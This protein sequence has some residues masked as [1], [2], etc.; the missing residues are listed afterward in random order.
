VP[1]VDLP[2]MELRKSS[3]KIHCGL[4]LVKYNDNG[5]NAY[6]LVDSFNPD[7]KKKR[8]KISNLRFYLSGDGV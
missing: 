4:Y 8:V 1:C 6:N 7:E 5:L 2:P 3:A